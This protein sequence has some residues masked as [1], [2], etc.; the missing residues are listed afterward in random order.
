MLLFPA[1]MGSAPLIFA[2]AVFTAATTLNRF[3]LLRLFDGPLVLSVPP[4]LP[5]CEGFSL[6]A[7]LRNGLGRFS[8]SE[9]SYSAV[10]DDDCSHVSNHLGV[11]GT[12]VLTRMGV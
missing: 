8:S 6:L 7:H 9:K 4:G 11:A 5:A 3:L 1:P 2:L 12:V 10:D